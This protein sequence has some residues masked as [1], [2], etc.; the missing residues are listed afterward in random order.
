MIRPNRAEFAVRLAREAG[1]LILSTPKEKRITP[2]FKSDHSIVTD[3]DKAADY[4]ISSRI[5]EYFPGETI[6]S[7]E[8]RPVYT[9]LQKTQ[10]EF[11]W[12][13]DPLDGT[14]NFSL[15]LPF[16][17]VS[18]ACIKDGF[19]F[20]GVI[21]FPLSNEL[22]SAQK[23]AGAFVN[24]EPL[25]QNNIYSHLSYFS[26]CSRTH[27]QFKVSVPYKTRILGSTCYTLCSVAKGTSILGFEATPKI[28]DIAA[29][30]IIVEEA[31]G[32]I[33]TWG[34]TKPF[35]LIQGINYSQ[36][37]FTTIAGLS[38]NIITKARQQIIPL[39]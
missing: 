4:L 3:A 27:Q 36:I 6:I 28:W 17:G 10:D 39:Q 7:E 22:F 30:W 29:G 35:P 1:E 20:V 31:G 23:A 24:D 25:V 37:N 12:I 13:I 11:V 33:N 9:Q 15:G 26:C 19:P 38:Q 8:L 32:S 14:T 21:Y 2:D 5:Q 16:W 18:I 34:D